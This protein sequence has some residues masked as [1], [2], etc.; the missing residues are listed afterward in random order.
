[1]N[2]LRVSAKARSGSNVDWIDA[3]Q[4]TRAPTTIAVDPV[5]GA[6]ASMSAFPNWQQY[7]VKQRRP[8]TGCIPTGYEIILR[9]ANCGNVNFETFQDEFDLDKDLNQG[10]HPRNN[11]DSVAKAIQAKY[12]SIRLMHVGFAKG[13]GQKKLQTVDQL[14]SRKLPVLVSLALA[15][16]GG[17]GWHIMPVVDSTENTLTLFWGLDENNLP[18]T[19]ALKKKDFVTV[20]EKYAGG[21]DIA[22]LEKA[23]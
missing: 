9:A 10:E 18:Q 16:F 14:I 17:R 1:M 12:P 20:H 5:E 8:A 19:K 21:D 6:T 4:E 23:A 11:F 7:I 3:G 2:Q 15:P 22:F 13:E